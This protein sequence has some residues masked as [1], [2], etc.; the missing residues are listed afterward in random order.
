MFSVPFQS[1]QTK[2]QHVSFLYCDNC[3]FKTENKV[4]LNSDNNKKSSKF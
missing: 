4:S 1:F 3:D 2:L